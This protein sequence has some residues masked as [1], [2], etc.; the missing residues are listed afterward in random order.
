MRR[1]IAA[2]VLLCAACD[3]GP[4]EL[5][6]R[7]YV[8]QEGACAALWDVDE[9]A[10]QWN[11]IADVALDVQGCEVADFSPVVTATEDGG[12]TFDP[13]RHLSGL[14]LRTGELAVFVVDRID[15]HYG[16]GSTDMLTGLG[17]EHEC[18]QAIALVDPRPALVAHEIGHVLG[19]GH[20]DRAANLMQSS[21]VGAWWVDD[22][23]IATAGE[24]F[25]ACY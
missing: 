18:S 25:A 4:G 22:V 3:T 19:L 8:S 14:D 2:L 11:A 9:A 12:G 5:P 20:D 7:L 17:V 1:P 24:A 10:E 15:A 16:D 21:P 23:Q 6:V 13:A